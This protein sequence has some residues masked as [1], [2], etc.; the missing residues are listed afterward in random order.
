MTEKGE[1][2]RFY[3]AEQYFFSYDPPQ[4]STTTDD[5]LVASSSSSTSKIHPLIDNDPSLYE[6]LQSIPEQCQSQ[7]MNDY[8][9]LLKFHTIGGP[10]IGKT[11]FLKRMISNTYRDNIPPANIIVDFYV[12]NTYVFHP[13]MYPSSTTTQD[14]PATSDPQQDRTTTAEDPTI[15][16]TTQPPNPPRYPYKRI[17]KIKSQVF[18][19][20]PISCF[21][22][23][24]KE[25]SMKFFRVSYGVFLCYDITNRQS[26]DDLNYW[27]K[28]ILDCYGELAT[29]SNM[30]RI[31]LLIGLK[32]DIYQDPNSTKQVQRQVSYE[33]GENYA[34][35]NN[36]DGFLEVSSRNDYQV[37][38]A[39][40]TMICQFIVSNN[41]I[42]STNTDGHGKGKVKPSRGHTVCRMF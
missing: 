22:G 23:T 3:S 15:L 28:M 1:K 21:H 27:L 42:T 8:H 37:K 7:S 25:F 14:V 10:S 32:Q 30:K 18:D 34:N 29:T 5:G 38:D 41:N 9:Y 31:V 20:V 6:E 39:L 16:S 4:T 40:A 35:E 36:L 26:F 24:S 2:K 19:R 33:E 13:L 11:S 17:L 12:H